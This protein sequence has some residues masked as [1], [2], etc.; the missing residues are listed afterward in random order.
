MKYVWTI[1][2]WCQAYDDEQEDIVYYTE[3]HKLSAIG[4]LPE[5]IQAGVV[6]LMLTGEEGDVPHH[7]SFA[8]DVAYVSPLQLPPEAPKRF[9]EELAAWQGL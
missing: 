2:E 4:W 3:S 7:V 1:E 9:H 6:S 5:D 8:E